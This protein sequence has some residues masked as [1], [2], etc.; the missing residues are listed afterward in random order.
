MSSF[1]WSVIDIGQYV[2]FSKTSLLVSAASIAFNPLF[3]NIVARSEYHYKTLSKIFV[4]QSREACYG[5]AITIFLLGLV[6]DYLYK[7]AIY[8][9]PTAPTLLNP[10][11]QA[12]AYVLFG[13]G[14]IL[15][16]TSTVALGITG[17]FLGD[18]FGILK[19]EMVTGFPFNFTSA[20][21]YLGSTLSFIGTALF[22]GKP[23]GLLLSVWV[24]IVYG[25]ALSF[26]D[27]FTA[28]IYAKRD[29]ERAAVKAGKKT[30]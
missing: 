17:T 30:A 16:L 18:Y 24:H 20:P 9:Q 29:R 6:R 1:D 7:Q 19:D 14:N 13:F 3:W 2:D 27:P 28:E 22:F 4:G 10:Y 8:E 5:L 21:M 23:A 25:I 26:E 11:F 12:A 15:V